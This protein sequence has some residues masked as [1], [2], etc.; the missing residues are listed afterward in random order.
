MQVLKL[1]NS[2]RSTGLLRLT[3]AILDL[4]AHAARYAVSEAVSLRAAILIIVAYWSARGRILGH[5]HARNINKV[6]VHYAHFSI[7]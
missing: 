7:D 3:S 5:S 2:N 6:G 1:L 4:Y